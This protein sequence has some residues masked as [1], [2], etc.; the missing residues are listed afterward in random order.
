M[1]DIIYIDTTTNQHQARFRQKPAVLNPNKD[2]LTNISEISQTEEFTSTTITSDC[3]TANSTNEEEKN[4]SNK[5][6][7]KVQFT[8][9]FFPSSDSKSNENKTNIFPRK[10]VSTLDDYL[11]K[12]KT[13]IKEI[14][15]ENCFGMSL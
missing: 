9:K 3:G 5:E 15:K 14:L 10:K 6:N 11:D 13:Y 8:K 7:R 4:L 1:N 12:I 2:T